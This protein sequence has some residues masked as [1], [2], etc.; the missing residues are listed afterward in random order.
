VDCT[1]E[2]RLPVAVEMAAYRV[3]ADVVDHAA[4]HGGASRVA[5]EIA[6]SSTLDVFMTVSAVDE[7][8]F[9][10]DLVDATD[11]VGALGGSVRA[12]ARGPGRRIEVAV[13]CAS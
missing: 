4:R 3:V 10:D 5:V 13:P 6:R 9:D 2:G 12:H 1:V 8:A 7:S 11:R